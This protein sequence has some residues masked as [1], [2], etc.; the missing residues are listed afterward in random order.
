MTAPS[1][2][3]FDLGKVLA[4]FDVGRMYR[5]VGDVAGIEPERVREVLFRGGLQ[6]ESELGRIS[7]QDFYEAFC[8]RTGTRADRQ[9]LELAGSDIFALNEDIL[10]V[11]AG[12]DRAGYRLGILSNTC[13]SHWKHCAR[14][15]PVLTESFRVY[16]LS[17]EIRAAKPDAA[18]FRAAA[19]LAGVPPEEIFFTDDIAENVDGARAAGFDAVEYTSASELAAELRRRGLRLDD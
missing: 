16:A 19:E 15:F 2:L 17:Y 9:S 11:V 13:R 4:N 3:Y 10:P 7:E 5:Q 8:E 14:R 12:L 18:I 1:F 6:K